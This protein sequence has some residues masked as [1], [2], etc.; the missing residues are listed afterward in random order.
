MSPTDLGPPRKPHRV[1][2]GVLGRLLCQI[3]A[4]DFEVVDV[5][6]GFG[7]NET[8]ERVRCRRCRRV[9][10]RNVRT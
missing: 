5:T 4:H 7:R 3:G 8:I 6:F 2:T 1:V 10:A 9:M